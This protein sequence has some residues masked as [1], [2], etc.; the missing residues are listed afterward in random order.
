MHIFGGFKNRSQ[1]W[2]PEKP[3]FTSLQE[4]IVWDLTYK[5]KIF[6]IKT[7][8]VRTGVGLREAKQ[9]VESIERELKAAA[10]PYM[11]TDK[12]QSMVQAGQKLQAIKYYREM[13]GVGLKE[14]KE[15]VDW[16]G[17]SLCNR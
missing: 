3:S 15:A 10:N 5:G 12:L 14:A 17:A 1:Q 4:E 6:A 16:L 2:E 7:Y 8:R 9:A 13:T 11:D